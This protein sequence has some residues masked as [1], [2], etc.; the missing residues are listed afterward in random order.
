MERAEEAGNGTEENSTESTNPGLWIAFLRK[1]VE[2]SELSKDAG[3]TPAKKVTRTW[4]INS[5]VL[6]RIL[7]YRITIDE[8]AQLAIEN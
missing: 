7:E 2:D 4:Y 3:T 5:K 6:K 1:V 8:L